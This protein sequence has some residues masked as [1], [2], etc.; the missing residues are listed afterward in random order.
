MLRLRKLLPTA[1]VVGLLSLGLSV[2]TAGTA[3]AGPASCGDFFKILVYYESVGDQA[4]ARALF[5]NM[6]D[7]GC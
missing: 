3:S 2:G 5:D 1:A 4:T 7:H 6:K